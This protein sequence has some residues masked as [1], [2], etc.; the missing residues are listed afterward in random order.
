MK[1]TKVII[2][3]AST[4]WAFGCYFVMQ[5]LVRGGEVSYSVPM[6]LFHLSAIAA[7]ILVVVHFIYTKLNRYIAVYSSIV[8]I[9]SAVLNYRSVLEILDVY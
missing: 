7:I 3:I 6:F 5:Q 8:L 1:N 2:P 4:I 9:I